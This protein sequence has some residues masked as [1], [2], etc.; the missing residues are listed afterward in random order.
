VEGWAS[1]QQWFDYD[2][3]SCAAPDGQSCG[4]YTQLV[5]ADTRRVGGGRANV[6]TDDGWNTVIVVA[7]Y[8]PAGNVD[9]QPPYS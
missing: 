9:G 2:G 6:T 3:N 5:W 1:E 7:N 8:G 4:H